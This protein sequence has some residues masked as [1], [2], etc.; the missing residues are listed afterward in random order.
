[1]VEKRTSKNTDGVCTVSTVPK[2]C[3]AKGL[4]PTQDSSEFSNLN[5]SKTFQGDVM[6]DV[7]RQLDCIQS[8]LDQ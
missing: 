5:L 1:M 7:H 4:S 2:L 6:V 8:K 3:Q